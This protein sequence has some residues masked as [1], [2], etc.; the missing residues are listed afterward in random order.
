MIRRMARF[1]TLKNNLG[2]SYTPIYFLSAL[3]NG[4]MAV[5]FF[6]YLNFMV[7]HPQTPI[8]TFD[9]IARFMSGASLPVRALILLAMAGIAFFGIRH[10]WLMVWNLREYVRYRQT[11]AF[12]HLRQSNSESKLIGLPLALAM[13]VNMSFAAGAAF[14]PGLWNIIEYLF[15][16]AMVAFLAVG[17]FALRIFITFFS[18]ILAKPE[19]D[20]SHNNN[21]GQLKAI[22][23]FGMVSV[24]FAAPAAMSMSRA[25]VTV[26]I[27]GGLFFGSVAV[28]LGLIWFILGFRSMLAHG[29]NA[30][31]AVSLW[32]PLPILTVLGVA[33]IRV[34][35]GLAFLFQI[36][37]DA[38][39]VIALRNQ[40]FSEAMFVWTT[41]ILAVMILFAVLGYA[42][43]KRVNYFETFVSGP[44]RSV[45][46]YALICPGTALFVFGMFFIHTGLVQTGLLE[47]YSLP[48]F[49]ILVPFILP[50]LFS[51]RTMLLLDEKLLRPL[52][53]DA[54]LVDQE[55]AT[56]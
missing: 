54:A 33:V 53:E 11:A 23:T 22:L 41:L 4:G 55:V 24:G 45:D 51:I 6:I 26:S 35:R 34:S 44:Q 3:G 47:R 9:G 27:I 28:V 32:I 49:I 46:S 29:I 13:T 25:T 1:V 36:P 17:I 37:A 15:P 16:V 40:A 39:N 38:P 48:Y 18:R 31:S 56:A 14:T 12:T 42:V 21:L 43:M 20:C 5:A 52:P 2:E 8:I 7:P 30:E 19:F 10:F 50:Q